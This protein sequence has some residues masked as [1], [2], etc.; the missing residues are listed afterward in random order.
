MKKMLNKKL[1]KLH[2]C[3]RLHLDQIQN[4]DQNIGGKDRHQHIQSLHG[5]IPFPGTLFDW[6]TLDR[7]DLYGVQCLMLMPFHKMHN[8]S[9]YCM[10]VKTRKAGKFRQ[11]WGKS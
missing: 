2:F 7:F 1:R 3:K 5:S 4:D 9:S 10:P 8:N 11:F 6:V